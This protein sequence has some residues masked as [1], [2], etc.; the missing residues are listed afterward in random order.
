M[1]RFLAPKKF[2]NVRIE[3]NVNRVEARRSL[4]KYALSAI[5]SKKPETKPTTTVSQVLAKHAC[6]A[7]ISIM[8]F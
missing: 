4:Y 6:E 7:R 8:Q 2:K 3:Q 5:P 1:I